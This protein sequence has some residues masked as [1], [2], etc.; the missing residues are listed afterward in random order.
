MV[1]AHQ[2]AILWLYPPLCKGEKSISEFALESHDLGCSLTLNLPCIRSSLCVW[3][4]LGNLITA[5]QN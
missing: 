2:C 1:G 5:L 3:R 4:Q